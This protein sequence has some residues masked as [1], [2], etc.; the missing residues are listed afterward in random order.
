M[1]TGDGIRL[2]GS[3]MV[4]PNGAHLFFRIII[5]YS[6]TEQEVTEQMPSI[7]SLNEPNILF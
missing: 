2:D 3:H 6:N 5:S 1:H 7:N 4:A